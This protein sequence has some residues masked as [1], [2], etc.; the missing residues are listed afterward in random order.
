LNPSS[1]EVHLGWVLIPMWGLAAR[2]LADVIPAKALQ[3]RLLAAAQAVVLFALAVFVWLNLIGLLDSAKSPDEIRMRW[4]AALGAVLLAG[5]SVLLVTWG[6][7]KSA[8]ASG[9]LW[10]AAALLALWNISALFNASGLGRNP[11]A[12]LWRSGPFPL[13]GDLLLGSIGDFSE[14]NTGFR[15][16]IDLAVVQV[17]SPAMKWALRDFAAVEYFEVTPLGASPSLA[18]TQDQP[19]PGLAAT[20]RGQDFQWMSAPDWDS[21]LPLDWFKWAVFKTAPMNSEKLILWVR[22]DRF[23]GA[24]AEQE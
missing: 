9:G 19:S 3:P 6:W 10:A 5:A 2:W 23:P 21:L 22:T 20:Y 17:P 1:G 18:L 13:D 24:S 16:T 12:Q 7:S 14:W 11:E 4:I 8:S 15:N